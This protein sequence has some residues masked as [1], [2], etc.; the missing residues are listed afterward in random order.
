MELHLEGK[1][2]L[3]TAS[4]VGIG[5]AIAHALAEEGTDVILNGRTQKRV[6]QARRQIAAEVPHVRTSG[7]A[8]DLSTAAGVQ[9]VTD[10]FESID[11]LVNNLGIF[12]VKPFHEIEDG[13]WYAF[14]ETNVMS[15]VR[16]SRHYLPRMKKNN[17][18]RIVFISSESGLHIPLEMIHYGVTKT[19]RSLWRG[20]WP[21]PPAGPL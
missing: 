20:D 5:F 10:R 7:V 1:T 11:I 21:K 17:W 18:G 14:F 8:A 16:L 6:E 15:G 4:T 19:A 2:A 13:D 3:L 12:D 9:Q